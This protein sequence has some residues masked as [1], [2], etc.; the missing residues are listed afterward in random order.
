VATT[1][2]PRN[3]L[4]ADAAS[5]LERQEITLRAWPRRFLAVVIAVVV[6][7]ASAIGG[8]VAIGLVMPRADTVAAGI[9]ALIVVIIASLGSFWLKTALTRWGSVN[10][11]ASGIRF[12]SGGTEVYC[13]WAL[14]TEPGQPDIQF[15]SS[16]SLGPKPVAVLLPVASAHVPMVTASR[17]GSVIAYGTE[18]K[19]RHV[20]FPSAREIILKQLGGQ[21]DWKDLAP[22]LLEVGRAR[23]RSG[24]ARTLL[25]GAAGVDASRAAD[26]G[27]QCPKCWSRSVSP[28][29]NPSI[30][31]G[32]TGY[33][34]NNCRLRMAPMRSRI[35]L[36]SL[37]G[38][39]V[40]L[41]VATLI[42][43]GLLFLI[44]GGREHG[45]QRI[46]LEL[47]VWFLFCMSCVVVAIVELRK[48]VPIRVHGGDSGREHR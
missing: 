30:L 45:F 19:A 8:V 10:F 26:L 21:G 43:F 13:P 28:H 16:F 42:L 41:A 29:G 11:S 14:F 39:A 36:W 22:L 27:L 12:K 37:F 33:Q 15:S 2:P 23:A 20:R 40:L 47:L 5:Y 24:D 6:W 9:A 1:L 31:D 32:K 4:L 17:N 18:I 44:V 25:A 7:L 35:A 3:F 38:I 46:H 34:C 48:P